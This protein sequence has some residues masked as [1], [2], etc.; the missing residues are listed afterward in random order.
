MIYKHSVLKKLARLCSFSSKSA[1]IYLEFQHAWSRLSIP[2]L[3]SR[4]GGL[5]CGQ[6]P[7]VT[8]SLRK[9]RCLWENHLFPKFSPLHSTAPSLLVLAVKLDEMMWHPEWNDVVDTQKE[10]RKIS[11]VYSGQ[12]EGSQT[13][14]L[15]VEATVTTT[16]AAICC[17]FKYILW[18]HKCRLVYLATSRNEGSNRP[19]FS[20]RDF[21]SFS[22]P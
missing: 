9:S 20:Q 15:K 18:V 7:F 2:G 19:L 22:S 1:S 11:P 6:K 5:S 21:W 17:V 4:W 16:L 3:K 8:Q 12:S 14:T 13:W 10:R